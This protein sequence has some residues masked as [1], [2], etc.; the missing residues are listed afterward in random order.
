MA[1]TAG[2]REFRARLSEYLREVKRGETVL[3]T[4]RGQVIA[5]V[6]P[7]GKGAAPN[8][9]R[10]EREA[11]ELLADGVVSSL[12]TQEGELPEPVGL[13]LSNKDVEEALEFVRGDRL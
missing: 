5:E 12:G 13:G 7:P 2:V 6:S 4:D 11:R 10:E 3:L 9:S 1:K 8:L